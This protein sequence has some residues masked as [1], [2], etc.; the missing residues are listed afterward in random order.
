LGKN[1]IFCGHCGIV[2][3]KFSIVS[4]FLRIFGRKCGS[5]GKFLIFLGKNRLT[6]KK[7]RFFVEKSDFL[8]KI[9]DI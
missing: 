5:L 1:P 2:D 7:F 3:E 8:G 6:W 9:S 4:D